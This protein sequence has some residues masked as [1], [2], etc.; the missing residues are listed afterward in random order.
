MSELIHVDATPQK[1]LFLS[2]IADYDIKTAICELVD[3]AI[4]HWIDGGRR[5]ILK[6]G[7]RVNLDRQTIVISDNAGGVSKD[8]L[9]LLVAPGASREKIQEGLIGNFGVGGKRAGIALGEL[10][11][12]K[13]RH[14]QGKTFEF[15]LSDKWL[16]QN[17]WNVDVYES[18]NIAANTTTVRISKMRQGFDADGVKSLRKH[19]A[20]TYGKFISDK[21]RLEFN[22]EHVEAVAFDQWAF[23]PD[24]SPVQHTGEIGPFGVDAKKVKVKITGGLTFDRDPS[25]RNYG[26]YFYC[27]ERLVLS[28]EKSHHVG[29][30]QKFAG[31]PHPDASLCRVIVELTG[32]PTQMPWNSSKSGINWSH[33]AYLE[34]REEIFALATRYSTISRRLKGDREGEVYAYKSGNL[35]TKK[36]KPGLTGKEIVALPVPRGRQKN[37][38][39]RILDQNEALFRKKPWVR[40]LIEA[41]GLAEIIFRRRYQT[42]NR[43]ALIVLDSTLEISLKEYLVHQKKKYFSD[44]Q[45]ADLFKSRDKVLKEIEAL[46]KVPK[47]DL[48]LARHYAN[49]RNKLIHER[50]TVNILDEDIITYKAV[51]DR[52][53]ERLFGADLD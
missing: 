31:V 22:G 28:H 49:L 19:L 42:K 11:E 39:E 13:T 34:I 41:V 18:E 40:G 38:P 35:S 20:E 17:D 43:V 14:K 9:Q 10:V 50:A 33:P 48:D 6:I 30:M 2:I 15:E 52:I 24:Y 27:N 29:F 8:D 44:S 26:V 4:D 16:S 32:M 47:R 7:V 3:N 36:L 12:I 21:C 25:D 23:P 51:T 5:N 45:I 53:V 46:T 1:R 37:Y